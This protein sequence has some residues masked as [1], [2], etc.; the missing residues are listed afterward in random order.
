MTIS[1]PDTYVMQDHCNTRIMNTPRLYHF[2]VLVSTYSSHTTH[3][4]SPQE[5]VDNIRVSGRHR[6]RKGPQ[7]HPLPGTASQLVNPTAAWTPTTGA[8]DPE[9]L[10]HKQH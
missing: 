2:Q 7:D 1:A 10:P 6:V 3:Q 9:Y 5:A 8:A 4:T